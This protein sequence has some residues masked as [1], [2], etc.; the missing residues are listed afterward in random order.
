MKKITLIIISKITL[1]IYIT[2]KFLIPSKIRNY[3]IKQMEVSGYNLHE[4]KNK[5]NKEAHTRTFKSLFRDFVYRIK[6]LLISSIYKNHSHNHLLREILKKQLSELFYKNDVLHITNY[7]HEIYKL[8]KQRIKKIVS[9]KNLSSNNSI[10]KNQIKLIA[11]YLP[12]FHPTPENNLWWGEGF[13]E[14]ANVTKAKPNFIGH[15]QPRLP[16]ALGFY[17]LRVDDIA[18]RQADLAKQNGIHGFCFYY[19]WFNG[20]KILDM[21]LERILSKNVPDIPF[22][23]CWANETWSRRWDGSENDILIAQNHTY[24]DDVQVIKDLSRFFEHKNYI[25]INDRPV[26]LVYRIELFPDIKA[27]A[28]LWR[29]YCNDEKIGNPYLVYVQSFLQS[30]L[31]E[32]P[33]KFGFD[34]AMEFP[35]H[36]CW[37]TPEENLEVINPDFKGIVFNYQ[38]IIE[39]YINKKRPAYTWFR[40]IMPSW[41]NTARK[42]NNSHI[43]VNSSPGAYRAW[44]EELIEETVQYNSISEQFI[45]INAWNE[46]GEGAY[47]EPDKKFKCNYLEATHDALMSADMREKKII[48]V[49]HDALLFG[50]QHLTLSIIKAL[51]RK[52]SL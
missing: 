46:W 9:K 47:L 17:D 10:E 5:L 16:S 24:E 1:Y 32:D 26:L 48:Y 19:Y 31:M 34:A 51:K 45:F 13:T 23:I 50:A 42:Q 8:T 21:P 14:L 6:Y 35:P 30:S 25:R 52:I 41:D 18:I 36:G 4:V 3:I 2:I 22:C 28:N 12:Q 49:G 39:Y 43:F 29:N 20:K 11:F 27:T 40:G 38:K 44:L 7:D 33:E 37:V 15:Y